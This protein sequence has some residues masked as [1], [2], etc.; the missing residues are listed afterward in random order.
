M[1]S[2][3]LRQILDPIV[4]SDARLVSIE[5]ALSRYADRCIRLRT[6]RRNE[7]LPFASEAVPWYPPGRW[8]LDF[9]DSPI[10]VS[11]IRSRRLLHSRCRILVGDQF[12]AGA[13]AS[14]DLRF[15]RCTRWKSLGDLGGPGAGRFLVGQR[16]HT[17]ACR[18]LRWSLER[19]ENP[20]FA[21]S[22]W[23]PEELAQQ[24]PGCFDSVLV[25]A[26]CSGQTLVSRGKR[27]DNAY[28]R[29]QIDHSAQR[30]RRILESAIRLLKPGGRLVYSTCTF[31]TAENE[32][33]DRMAHRTSTWP[34]ESD[35]AE[36]RISRS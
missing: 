32:K 8:I 3:T 10:D 2:E 7:E 20:R 15:V 11:A 12:V 9:L 5:A 22:Q 31:A 30:Q 23:D 24:F 25:D 17:N 27:S 18:I 13:A 34:L 16:T 35:R 29:A 33:A 28:D 21:I 36:A 19:T 26:P 14:D 4:L 1:N 6:D